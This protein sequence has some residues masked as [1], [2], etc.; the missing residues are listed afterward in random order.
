MKGFIHRNVKQ[1][2]EENLFEQLSQLE[3]PQASESS[4]ESS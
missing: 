1:S 4:S 2:Y 3:L